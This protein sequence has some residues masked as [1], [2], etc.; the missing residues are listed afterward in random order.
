[1]ACHSPS[2][3]TR[4]TLQA[5]TRS[6]SR[7]GVVRIRMRRWPLCIVSSI[8]L[9]PSAQLAPPTCTSSILSMTPMVAVTQFSFAPR[10]RRGSLFTQSTTCLLGR[11]GSILVIRCMNRRLA[12][13]RCPCWLVTASSA[14]IAHVDVLLWQPRITCGSA[15]ASARLQCRG[16]PI[17]FS[18]CSKSPL[19]NWCCPL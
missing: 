7:F 5:S 12:L 6:P 18:P 1:M 19:H 13:S 16:I 4:R 15:Y 10:S 14:R 9:C 8:G 3:A 11:C 17:V 2:S